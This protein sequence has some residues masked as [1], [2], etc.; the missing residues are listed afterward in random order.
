MTAS[1]GSI[2]TTGFL[3]CRL[4]LV[5]ML[6]SLL[7]FLSERTVYSC[8]LYQEGL[9]RAANV[10]G[11]GVKGESS[12]RAKVVATD[13]QVRLARLTLESNSAEEDPANIQRLIKR[14]SD[15]IALKVLLLMLLLLLHFLRSVSC[16]P[17]SGLIDV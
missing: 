7:G 17:G 8:S 11:M 6:L 2:S 13:D 16:D 1:F 10:S 14:V 15:Y 4:G 12:N 3:G 5:L 9:E